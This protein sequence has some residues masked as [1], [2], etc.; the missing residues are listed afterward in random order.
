M[1]HNFIYRDFPQTAC[2][3]S[4]GHVITKRSMRFKHLVYLPY[5]SMSHSIHDADPKSL[6]PYNNET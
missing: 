5:Q 2:Y 3:V 6:F 4:T 1:L